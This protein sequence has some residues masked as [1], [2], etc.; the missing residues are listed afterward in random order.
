MD[1]LL[2]IMLLRQEMPVQCFNLLAFVL[3]PWKKFLTKVKRNRRL[4]SYANN[5][6]SPPDCVESIKFRSSHSSFRVRSQYNVRYTKSPNLYS[7][8]ALP[9]G[10][11]ALH[12]WVPCKEYIKEKSRAVFFAL[13]EHSKHPI[14]FNIKSMLHSILV[15]NQKIMLEIPHFMRW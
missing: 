8:T 5:G 10:N 2:F 9:D 6:Q 4:K 15:T 11:T 3:V 1:F 14:D 7:R 13:F 12:K